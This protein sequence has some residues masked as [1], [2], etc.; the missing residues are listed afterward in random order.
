MNTSHTGR[1]P[2]PFQREWLEHLAGQTRGTTNWG[3]MPKKR[4]ANG[5]RLI[6]GTNKTWRPMVA[7]GW[8]TA[9]Y[10]N[11]GNVRTTDWWFTITPKG[12]E[13]LSDDQEN[14]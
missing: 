11:P 7:A 3:L 14:K 2:T 13:A 4:S 10:G 6:S 9:E 5:L 1:K 12:R 8:I